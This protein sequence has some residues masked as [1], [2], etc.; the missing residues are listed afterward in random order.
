MTN[1]LNTRLIAAVTATLAVTL[2]ACSSSSETA[3]S[4]AAGGDFPVTIAH[5]FGETVID[6]A[7]ER[8]VTWGFGST[9]TAL[10]LGV[11]P[12][13]IPEQTYGGDEDGLLPWIKDTLA[14]MGADT[15]S[16][17]T[18]TPG[19]DVPVEQIAAAA[20]DLILAN[21]SGITAADYDQLS[22]IAPTVAYPDEPWATPWR[23]VVTTVGEAL[24]R[25]DEARALLDDLDA[26]IAEKAAA[27]PQLA[28]KTVAAV[29]PDPETFYVYTPADSRVEFLTALGLVSAPSV[30][31]LDTGEESF[32]YTLS[33]E[34]VATLDS[35]I[36]L[37]YANDEDAQRQFLDAAYAQTMTQV[38]EG[39]VAQVNGVELVA[40]VSPPTV[41]SL[42]WGIDEYLELLAAAVR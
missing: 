7:P 17:L 19:G 28:G 14:E 4:A 9:D 8:V 42:T 37:S 29:W 3:T 24:G 33:F 21:Y 13:A 31:A 40:A 41:L 2:S 25:A 22:R 16:I 36:L 23:D 27:Y 26:T 20:L 15:P 10:A 30:D 11:V 35:D 1:R 34:E 39:R 38:T 12:V 5:A 6:S 32:Y 18:N